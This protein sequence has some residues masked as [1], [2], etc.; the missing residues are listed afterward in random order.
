M[1]E[2]EA[3]QVQGAPTRRLVVM[4]D[5]TGNE[6][7]RN[8]SNVLKL[9]R[10]LEKND[11]QRVYYDPGIGTLEQPSTWGRIKSKARAVAGLALGLGLDRNVLDAYA[12]LARE[13]RA[14]DELFLL[15]YS[16]GAYTARVLAGF[17]HLVG[18][19]KPDQLNLCGSALRA[20]KRAS[21]E[22]DLGIGWEFKRIAGA[23]QVQVRF[24]GV[25]D[26]VASVIVPRPDRL[27]V[28][29]LETLPYTKQNPS[30]QI[31][32]QACSIDERRRMFRLLPWRE[33]QEYIP[34]FFGPK[35]FAQQDIRQVWFAGEHGDVGGG[36]PEEESAL[37]KFPLLWMAQEAKAAGLRLNTSMVNHLGRGTPRKN[38]RHAYV[39]PDARGMVHRSLKGAWLALEPLPKSAKLREWKGRRTLLGLYIPWGEPRPMPEDAIVHQSVLDRVAARMGYGPRNLPASPRI[40]PIQ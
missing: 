9:Y 26:T 13:Y 21:E 29:S 7:G 23:R 38:S 27:Y 1:T 15:G 32:R 39:P 6:I 8:L 28:P 17:L 10:M 12:F 22:D 35:P 4:L 31:F 19:L 2:S 33:P 37:S 3:P 24:V 14:G 40:E 34:N 5:G 11:G 30:V 25:W 16:R 36:Y 18:L 20:Y